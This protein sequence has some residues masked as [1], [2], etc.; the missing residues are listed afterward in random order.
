[1]AQKGMILKTNLDNLNSI[2]GTQMVEGGTLHIVPLPSHRPCYLYTCM[3]T[4][5]MY[6][7][8]V[9]ITILNHY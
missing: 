7:L 8:S 4:S 6:T 9:I 1:M 3:Y 5:H 2:P